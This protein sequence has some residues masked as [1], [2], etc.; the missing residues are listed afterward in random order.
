MEIKSR[1]TPSKKPKNEIKS[2]LHKVIYLTFEKSTTFQ[3]FL[4]SFFFQRI[5]AAL[6]SNIC[7][8]HLDNI[9]E[10]KNIPW[11]CQLVNSDS[12]LT[13]DLTNWERGTEE[14]CIFNGID[15]LWREFFQQNTIE[16]Q[17]KAPR[18]ESLR[19]V[20]NAEPIC[21]R[22]WELYQHHQL[23]STNSTTA[24]AIWCG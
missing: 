12:Q 5:T 14:L 18:L 8:T 2:D 17:P 10:M 1:L 22:S 15:D 16:D 13:W 3:I 24:A 20:V 7:T 21:C 23:N 11:C 6:N 4:F 19:N 9:R